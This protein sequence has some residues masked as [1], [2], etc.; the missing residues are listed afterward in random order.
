[1][2]NKQRTDLIEKFIRE[3]TYADLRTLASKF[4]GSI[5]TVRRALDT[6]EERG[7]V[8][9]HH[10]G[11]SLIETDALTQEYDFLSR[12]QRQVDAKYAIASLVAEQIEPGMTVILDGGSTTYAVARLVV[13]KRLQV[14]TNSLPVASLFGETG[15]VETTVTGGSIYGRLGVLVGPMCEQSFEQTHADVAVLGGAGITEN[16]IWNY[17]ALIVAAQRKMIAAAERTIFAVDKSKFGRK[18]L[19]L[20]T[21]F[22]AKF[23]IVTDTLPE[24][25]VVNA[26]TASGATL[27]LAERIR[28]RR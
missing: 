2:T 21:A 4:G 17:N 1:M 23:T 20:T 15:H 14:I 9:R 6:L 5:S 11:A 19:G 7:I 24:P 26:I 13:N 25:A 12:N 28:S 18:A 3:N 22:A 10:G 16:G 8:R 27:T